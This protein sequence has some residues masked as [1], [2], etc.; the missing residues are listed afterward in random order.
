MGMFEDLLSGH[1]SEN[2]VDPNSLQIDAI[3]IAF[4]KM[5]LKFTKAIAANS[6]Y[7]QAVINLLIRKEI[8]TK[9]EIEESITKENEKVSDLF[10][11]V[12]TIENQVKEMEEKF[13]KDSAELLKQNTEMQEFYDLL[14]GKKKEE[15]KEDKDGE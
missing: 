13:A 3:N 6:I 12:E 15:K 7:I 1:L 9:E 4:K 2:S 10:K 11:S 8:I 14:M 5:E